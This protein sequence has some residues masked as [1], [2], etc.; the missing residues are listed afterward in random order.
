MINQTEEELNRAMSAVS[1][2]DDID[3]AFP[4][5]ALMLIADYHDLDLVEVLDNLL[6]GITYKFGPESMIQDI[7][8]AS[9]SNPDR[10]MLSMRWMTILDNRMSEL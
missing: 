2:C 1:D 9:Q 4:L 3:A 10:A 6:R 7:I 8:S 5:D